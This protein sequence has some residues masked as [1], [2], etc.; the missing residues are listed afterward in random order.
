MKKS[1]IIFA[2]VVIFTILL[3][4]PF[5]LIRY[6]SQFNLPALTNASL[7]LWGVF[8]IMLGIMI[9]VL[10][11]QLFWYVG[12]GTPVPFEPPFVLVE[13][14]LFNYS[15]NP[16]YL[17]FAAILLGISLLYGSLLLYLYFLLSLPLLH[18]FV[19]RYE[20]PALIK[21]FGEPYINYLN[22]VPRWLIR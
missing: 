13:Q 6:N 12:R 19:I 18:L 15:R 10:V 14:G 7:S 17:G 4:V 3:M 5:L 9:A 21:R 2:V 20:E 11:T 8:L 1:S 22:R 16:M